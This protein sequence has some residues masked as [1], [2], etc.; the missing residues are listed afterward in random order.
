MNQTLVFQMTIP[1]RASHCAGNGELLTPGMDY[2]SMLCNSE[3]EGGFHRYDYCP[4]CWKQVDKEGS[5]SSWKSTVPKRKDLLEQPKQRD[6][7]ALCLLKEALEHSE[8]PQARE[9][10]FIL[11]LYLQRRRRLVVRQE[12]TDASGQVSTLYEA[13]ESEEM[14]CV[15]KLPLSALQIASLQTSLAAKFSGC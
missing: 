11:A 2:Y 12:I 13:P 8:D 9:E 3:H 1:R 15:P 6:A 10:A 4:E 5:I 14:F 7:R